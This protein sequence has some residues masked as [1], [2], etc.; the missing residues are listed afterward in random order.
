MPSVVVIMELDQILLNVHQSVGLLET[1][2][3]LEYFQEMA[4]EK[5]SEIKIL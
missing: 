4:S 5:W 2:L 1:D 3:K